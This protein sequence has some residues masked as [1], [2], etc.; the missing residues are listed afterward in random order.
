MQINFSGTQTIDHMVV[1]SIP[2]NYT[3]PIEPTD[4]M[5]SFLYGVTGFTVQGW[6][7]SAWMTLGMV[8]RNHRVKRTDNLSAFTSRRI[9][10][11]ITRSLGSYSRLAEI[12]AWGN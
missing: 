3:N 8:T 7:G 5:T 6:D 2:D 11:N 4:T 10:I 1:Y 9:R 12:E